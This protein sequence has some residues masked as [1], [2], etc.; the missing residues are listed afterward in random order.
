MKTCTPGSRGSRSVASQRPIAASSVSAV[1]DVTARPFA[2]VS[3]TSTSALL[4]PSAGAF[5][6]IASA[7]RPSRS[8][9]FT[10]IAVRPRSVPAASKPRSSRRFAPGARSTPMY[11]QACTPLAASTL[12][13]PTCE[14]GSSRPLTNSAKCAPAGP[15][16]RMWV[17]A[18][19][20]VAPSARPMKPSSASRFG[21]SASSGSAAGVEDVGRG[22]TIAPSRG[23]RAAPANGPVSGAEPEMPLA[24]SARVSA[25]PR[26]FAA[27]S[28]G[29]TRLRSASALPAS[30]S[31]RARRAAISARSSGVQ[32]SS[33]KSALCSS[34]AFRS[35]K[36]LPASPALRW[37]STSSA[38]PAGRLVR[39]SLSTWV[40]GST[41]YR[42]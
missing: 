33:A 40:R 24:G 32:P 34:P 38:A 39:S 18:I 4:R 8:G 21:S 29:R 30:R 15:L 31:A 6:V 7:S 12:F 14:A 42:L 36:R 13:L 16:T 2:S 41:P 3:L 22:A 25:G 27:G 20:K 37:P 1:R 9:A 28:S 5:R 23:V 17:C 19:G 10:P 26:G 11:S 35:T